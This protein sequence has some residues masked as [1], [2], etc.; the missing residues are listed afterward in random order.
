VLVADKATMPFEPS[1]LA[2]TDPTETETGPP[3]LAT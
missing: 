2:L 1:P 3:L